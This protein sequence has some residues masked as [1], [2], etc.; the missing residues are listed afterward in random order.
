MAEMEKTNARYCKRCKYACKHSSEV[1]CC[2]ILHTGHSR[3]CPIGMC[4]KFEKKGR[5]RKVKLK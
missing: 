3:G 2:Y 5:K 4:D 1:I